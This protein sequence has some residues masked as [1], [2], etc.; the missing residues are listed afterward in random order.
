MKWFDTEEIKNKAQLSEKQIEYLKSPSLTIF[1]PFNILVRKHWDLLIAIIGLNIISAILLEMEP[2]IWD[3]AVLGAML[4]YFYFAIWNGRRLAWNRND[5][6]DF[7]DFKRSEGVWKPWGIIFFA[8]FI[9]YIF[10]DLF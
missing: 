8:I 3:L 7:N 6:K 1:G 5:W 10:S 2:T 9:L 4:W